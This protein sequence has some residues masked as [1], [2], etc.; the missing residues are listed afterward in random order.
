MDGLIKIFRFSNK[1]EWFFSNLTLLENFHVE[2]IDILKSWI[3]SRFLD[4]RRQRRSQDN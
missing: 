3:V 2:I 4:R 1:T